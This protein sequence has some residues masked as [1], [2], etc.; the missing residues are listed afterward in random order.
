MHRDRD[1]DVGE[2]LPPHRAALIQDLELD[3]LLQAMAGDDSLVLDVAR[4]SLLLGLHDDPDTILYRQAVLKDCLNRPDVLRELYDL[5]GAGQGVR[6]RSFF[7]ILSRHPSGILY[8]SMEVVEGLLGVLRKLRKLA[9]VHGERVESEGLLR[10]FAML[11]AEL[12]EAYLARIEEH[13]K[14]LQFHGGFLVSASLG[15]GCRPADYVLRKPHGDGRCWIKRM[16]GAQPPGYSFR[17]ADRDEA[18]L[19]ALSDL[20]ARGID[21]VANALAQST[22]HVLS[23]FDVL[24]NELAFYVGCVNLKAKLAALGIATS[25]PA[26]A[27]AR[28]RVHRARGLCDACLALALGRAVVTNAVQADGRNLVVVTGANQGGKSSFLR[29]IGLAQLM[30]QSGMFVAAESFAASLCTGLFTHY[31]REEDESMKR[32]KLDEEL[33]RMSDLADLVSR[34]ALVL[35]NE[36]FASTNEREGSE[37]ARQIVRALVDKGVGVFFVTHLHDFAR[38]A[39]D[40]RRDDSMFLRAERRADGTRTFK[41]VDGAPLQT[42]YGPDVYR[43]VFSS[44]AGRR[45]A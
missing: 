36:S 40:E 13:L 12:T 30:M 5:A 7:G 1:F 38:G 37:I 10:L 27:A 20:R 43:E 8:G 28:P 21:L 14:D 26:P 23:F 18:G 39:F 4:K 9:E 32:G 24:R 11:Q 22:D 2:A 25:F 34:D 44:D 29:A 17:V 45:V 35:F 16:L 42:S 19:R 33:H 3:T 31:G 41:I 6:K 15:E